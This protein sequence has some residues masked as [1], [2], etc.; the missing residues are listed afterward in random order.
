M[1]PI[2]KTYAIDNASIVRMEAQ[3]HSEKEVVYTTTKKKQHLA[4][5]PR[6]VN[7]SAALCI[8]SMREI[9]LPPLP[10]IM[11]ASRPSLWGAST[12]KSP[13]K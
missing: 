1:K 5:S 4:R 13:Y 11:P 9:L 12:L 2:F 8:N 3:G 6:C 10:M 7:F